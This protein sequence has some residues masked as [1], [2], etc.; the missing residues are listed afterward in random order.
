MFWKGFVLFVLLLTA[1]AMFFSLNVKLQTFVNNFWFYNS[2]RKNRHYQ[3][4]MAFCFVLLTVKIFLKSFVYRLFNQHYKDSEDIGCSCC[5]VCKVT[6]SN[7]KN[8]LY[9]NCFVPLAGYN[10]YFILAHLMSFLSISFC[11]LPK[12]FFSHCHCK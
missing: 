4:Y 12:C 5:T 1:H 10:H 8:S 6:F 2:L 7:I 11:S 3:K 9:G